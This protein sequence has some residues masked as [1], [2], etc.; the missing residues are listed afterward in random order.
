M[1]HVYFQAT[2]IISSQPI[3]SDIKF[4][5][6]TNKGFRTRPTK[7]W[8]VAGSHRG[9]T[10]GA[11]PIS[12]GTRSRATPRQVDSRESIEKRRQ[13][14]GDSEADVSA[15][16]YLFLSE[17]EGAPSMQRPPAQKNTAALDVPASPQSRP[18]HRLIDCPKTFVASRG[19]CSPRDSAARGLA[20]KAC[21]D[22]ERRRQAEQSRVGSRETWL[23][24]VSKGKG[25][26]NEEQR[27]KQ[28]KRNS[29]SVLF[30]ERKQRETK[31]LFECIPVVSWCCSF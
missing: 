9:L 6:A 16:H 29:C 27:K 30:Q 20:W 4:P 18:P 22:K 28:D 13:H 15:H 3:F 23:L 11:A 17:Y 1:G 2:F 5:H 14:Y 7:C 25:Q 31:E 26:Q 21:V 12:Q 24:C 8:V 19:S 10:H